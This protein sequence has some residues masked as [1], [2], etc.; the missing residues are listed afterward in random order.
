VVEALI[1][2][3]ERGEGWVGRDL[4]GEG[5]R[6]KFVVGVFRELGA[7]AAAWGEGGHDGERGE[8]SRGAAE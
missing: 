2:G 6:G 3:V 1:V 8:D 5:W 7:G 4:V